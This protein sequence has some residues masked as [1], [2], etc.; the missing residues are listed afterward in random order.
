[1]SVRDNDTRH[2]SIKNTNMNEKTEIRLDS[3]KTATAQCPVII[4]ASRSTGKS[5]VD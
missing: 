3:G 5:R 2:R 1:M 4:S